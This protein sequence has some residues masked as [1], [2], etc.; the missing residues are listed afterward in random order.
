LAPGAAGLRAEA[1]ITINLP[2]YQVLTKLKVGG[3]GA[4]QAAEVSSPDL[5]AGRL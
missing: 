3:D 5:S 4:R 2:L 1:A